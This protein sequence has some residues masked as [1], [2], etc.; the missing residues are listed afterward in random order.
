[1]NFASHGPHRDQS[2]QL[3]NIIVESPADGVMG[4][5]GLTILAHCLTWIL[6]LFTISASATVTHTSSPS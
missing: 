2:P 1:M 3:A 5:G 6:S 4:L